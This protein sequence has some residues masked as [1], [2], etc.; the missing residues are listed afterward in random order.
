MRNLT[1]Q[2]L[3]LVA[4]FSTFGLTTS[5]CNA[6]AQ[7]PDRPSAM[8]VISNQT[9]ISVRYQFRWGSGPWIN[10]SLD[11]NSSVNHWYNLDGKGRAPEFLIRYDQSNG[12]IRAHRLPWIAVVNSNR[13]EDAAQYHFAIFNNRYWRLYKD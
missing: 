4:V 11:G 9:E 6:L 7:E 10:Y 1:R 5:G 8:V 12:L 3:P 13:T 2:L